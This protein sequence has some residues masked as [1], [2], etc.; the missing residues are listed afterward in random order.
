[1]DR[2]RAWAPQGRCETG[3]G[4]FPV[5]AAVKLP[6]PPSQLPPDFDRVRAESN[7]EVVSPTS[8]GGSRPDTS[9]DIAIEFFSEPK[10]S[11]RVREG[12]ERM[13]KLGT[14]PNNQASLRELS[15]LSRI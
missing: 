13:P 12:T 5:V 10:S 15:E 2:R 1:M 11:K 4:Q 14:M 6:V 7:T 8:S 3:R 9:Y